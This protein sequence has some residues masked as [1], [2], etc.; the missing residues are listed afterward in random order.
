MGAGL[1]IKGIPVER[2]RE[3]SVKVVPIVSSARAAGMIFKMWQKT[4]HDVPDAVIVEGPLAGGHLGFSPEQIDDPDFRLEAIV[5][6]VVEALAP[7]EKAFGRPIPVIAAGGVYSGEDIHRMLELGAAGVQ[8]ATRFVATAE[9]DAD[10]VFKQSYVDSTSEE[11]GLIKSPVGMPGR[12]IR[13]DFIVATEEGRRPAFRCAWKCLSS[14]DAESAKYCI[15]VA[16]NNARKGKTDKGFVF[17][18]AN[19]HRVS[20][21]VPVQSLV[22]EL[23]EGYR[24][25]ARSAAAKKLENLVARVQVLWSEH[26]G[27]GSRAKQLADAYEKAVAARVRDARDAGLETIRKQY[28]AALEKLRKLQLQITEGLAESWALLKQPIGTD[29]GTTGDA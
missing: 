13:N 26:D 21:I 6:G 27:L 16:L 4:Y 20:E 9:C 14:C 28:T 3:N 23:S 18:G 10:D 11:I 15:S 22:D 29:P 7:Y 25:A 12:A 2:L 8:M 19:A 5:P 24:V 17:A 1:P